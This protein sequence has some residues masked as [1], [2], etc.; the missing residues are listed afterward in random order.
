MENPPFLLGGIPYF[1]S[2]RLGHLKVVNFQK[3]IE[4]QFAMSGYGLG[5]STWRIVPFPVDDSMFINPPRSATRSLIPTS[6]KCLL[7][8][9]DA[10]SVGV[11]RPCPSS[12]KRINR[13][14][15]DV[16]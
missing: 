10:K 4:I 5:I 2:G 16:Y 1:T 9:R 12:S 11:G 3:R 6:P 14:V 7:T 8:E 13:L 15:D